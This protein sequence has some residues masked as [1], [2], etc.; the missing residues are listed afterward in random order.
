MVDFDAILNDVLEL[1]NTNIMSTNQCHENQPMSLLPTN[2][3][4]TNQ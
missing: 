3:M 2:V 1:Q 4:R